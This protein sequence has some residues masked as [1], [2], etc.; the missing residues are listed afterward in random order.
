M[1][2][3]LLLTIALAG[4]CAGFAQAPAF[5]VASVRRNLSDEPR[6]G[7][8]SRPA[9]GRFQ[10]NNV[11][12]RTLIRTAYDVQDFQISSGPRWV[13]SYK[14]DVNAKADGNADWAETRIMLQELLATRFKLSLSRESRAISVY[15]M[16]VAKDGPRLGPPTDAACQPPPLGACG[17][18]RIVNR[19]ALSGVNVST[20]QIARVLT[21]FM[22]RPVLDKTGL[23][24]VFDFKMDPVRDLLR[25]G[26]PPNPN[27][28]AVQ[29]NGPSIFTAL[30]EQLGLRL[31]SQ[32]SSV[33][34]IVI[35]RAEE[36]A[37]N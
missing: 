3:T 16:A 8:I 4:A 33:E 18:I 22:D 10:A 34:M 7:S 24:G 29:T 17:G 6:G 21:T 11:T 1:K 12:L 28:V 9:G 19:N 30:E 14:F 35:S 20:A 15:V 25:F 2:H 32:K 36:P 27:D 37:E 13:D 23:S 26:E 31:M 5:E